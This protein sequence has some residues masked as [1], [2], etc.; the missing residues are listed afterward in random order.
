MEH[1]IHVSNVSAGMADRRGRSRPHHCCHCQ[2]SSQMSGRSLGWRIL[3]VAFLLNVAWE[4]IQMFAYANMPVRSLQS[5]AACSVAALGDGLYVV[6]LYWVGRLLTGDIQ[7]V[8]HLTA[9]RIIMVLACG[10]GFALVIEHIALLHRFWQYRKNM[11]ILPF[12]VG[13][14]PV[15]QLMILPLVTFRVASGLSRVIP[16]KRHVNE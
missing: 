13:L 14:W 10:L 15:L 11:P 2:A 3:A 16:S 8:R 1:A 5:L 6:A 7:W 12:G 4:M 9:R